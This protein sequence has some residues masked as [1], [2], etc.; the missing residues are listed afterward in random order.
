MAL[1]DDIQ[2]VDGYAEKEPA[3]IADALNADRRTIRK[4]DLGELLFLMNNRGML[5]RLMYPDEDGI[6]W[7]GTV[8]NMV[9]HVRANAP[10]FAPTIN[11]W[12]S[13]ITND[14]NTNF[15]TSDATYA[16]SFQLIRSNFAG[17]TGMPTVA[18]FDAIAGLGGGYRFNNV[19]AEQVTAALSARDAETRTQTRLS[20]LNDAIDT[21][22]QSVDLAD[23]SLTLEQVQ[24]AVSAA[25]A[26]AW[27]G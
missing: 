26:N 2:A 16:A 12:F 1:I 17:Q 20:T 24:S 3:E 22:R 13:H 14:R 21:A 6:K 5:T 9:K 11:Q 23:A 15:D 10:Q 25:I 7:A 4:I 18:D 27:G 19:T 8:V